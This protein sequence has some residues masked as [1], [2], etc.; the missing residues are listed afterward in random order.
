MKLMSSSVKSLALLALLAGFSPGVSGAD[1]ADPSLANPTRFVGTDGAFLYRAAC[2]GCHM[3]N[4]E[5][6]VG[7]GAYP[8][9]A[10]N[11]RLQAAAYPVFMVVKGRKAMPAFGA[12]LDDA[13]VA[14]LV[15]YIRTH[16]G[17]EYAEVVTPTLVESI[18]K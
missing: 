7:A 18:R 14:S 10:N 3:A 6:A 9:L 5:G 2:Q 16:F 4:G 11:P 12:L 17:N 15:T 8:A 1:A 13:Q